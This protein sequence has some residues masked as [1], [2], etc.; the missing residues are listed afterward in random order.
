MTMST[1]ERAEVNRRNAQRSCGPK[2]ESGKQRARFNA[3]K[4]GM[5][6][7]QPILPGEDPQARQARLDAWTAQLEPRDDVE[8]F[9]VGRAVNLSWQLERAERAHAARLAD[10]ARR[11][12]ARRPGR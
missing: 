8:R 10:T 3:I 12:P 9:L 11:Q 5:R 2:S 7:R 1:S 4:H 6:A